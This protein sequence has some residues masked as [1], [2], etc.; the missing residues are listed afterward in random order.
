M[1]NRRDTKTDTNKTKHV[2]HTLDWIGLNWIGLFIC[3][4]STL[5]DEMAEKIHKYITTWL[6]S[7]VLH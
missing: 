3:I 6:L 7:S 4:N 1:R 5:T 2:L